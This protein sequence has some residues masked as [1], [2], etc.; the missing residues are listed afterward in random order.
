MLY[1]I[2]GRRYKEDFI[3]Y[4]IKEQIGVSGACFSNVDIEGCTLYKDIKE[5]DLNLAS[6]DKR[7]HIFYN[8]DIEHSLIRPLDREVQR[9]YLIILRALKSTLVDIYFVTRY[10]DSLD[11]RFRRMVESRYKVIRDSDKLYY[12][13]V[14]VEFDE[15]LLEDDKGFAEIQV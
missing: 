9:F 10:L 2:E 4:F 8:C 1:T 13:E 3:R 15:P 5:V 14:K 12:R 7:I 11:K 6:K